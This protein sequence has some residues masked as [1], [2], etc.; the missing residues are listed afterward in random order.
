MARPKEI[1]IT[2]NSGDWLDAPHDILEKLRSVKFDTV[3]IDA[4]APEAIGAQIAQ[5]ILAAQKTASENDGSLKIENASEAFMISLKILGLS[6][7]F[8]E[9]N[10]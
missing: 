10:S 9:L 7:V 1:H 8:E 4:S 2:L 3:T 6:T 5:L